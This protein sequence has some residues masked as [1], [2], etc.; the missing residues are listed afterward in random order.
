VIRYGR[1]GSWIV[2]IWKIWKK[3]KL[4]SEKIW[5]IWKKSKFNSDKIWTIR[6]KGKLNSE[7]IWKIWKKGKLNSEKILKIQKKI[8]KWYGKYGRKVSWNQMWNDL[9]NMEEK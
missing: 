6:K 5:K 4:N 9:E 2:K 1:K 8:V 3:P 7:K